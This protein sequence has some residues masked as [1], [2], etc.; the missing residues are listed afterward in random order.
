L[1]HERAL[2]G[3]SAPPLGGRYTL[4]YYVVVFMERST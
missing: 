2:S 1:D 4:A 3:H